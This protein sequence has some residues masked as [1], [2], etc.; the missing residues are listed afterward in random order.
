MEKG[1]NKQL[2]DG[3]VVSTIIT[4]ILNGVINA[5]I[6]YFLD[7][8]KAMASMTVSQYTAALFQDIMIT[9]AILVMLNAGLGIMGMQKKKTTGLLPCSGWMGRLPWLFRRPFVAGLVMGIVLGPVVWG[10]TIGI[11]SLAGVQHISLWGFTIYKGIYT[12][13]LGGLAS[14]VAT[15]AA[16][17]TPISPK[18]GAVAKGTTVQR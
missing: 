8:S 2:R 4:I 5:V 13:I 14:I 6:A 12:A 7:S 17:H 3:I 10:L 9:S 18:Q 11:F 1:M 16:L 15:I